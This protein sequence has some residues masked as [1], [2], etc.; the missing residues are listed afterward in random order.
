MRN[1]FVSSR[2]TKCL[3]SACTPWQEFI[4][5]LIQLFLHF[6]LVVEHGEL[7][8]VEGLHTIHDKLHGSRYMRLT[9]ML[10]ENNSR[11]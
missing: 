7:P 9:S 6:G 11:F 2:S 10:R 4:E 5:K 8:P 1:L 3:K